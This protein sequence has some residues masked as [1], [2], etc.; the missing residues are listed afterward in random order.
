MPLENEHFEDDLLML[1]T[2]S[3]HVDELLYDGERV[4]KR[5]DLESATVV[6]TNERVLVFTEGG[7]G[8]NY[9]H[10]DR[11]NV[12]RVS[13]ENES[14]L[15]HLVWGTIVLFLAI[16]LFLLAATYD[17]ADA[18]DGVDPGDSTGLAGSVIDVVETLL[19][20]FDLT[21]FAAGGVVAL[22]G[23]IFFVRY[24]RSRSRHLVLR[25]SGDDDIVLPVTDADIEADR[26]VDLH[27]AIGPGSDGV[28]DAPPEAAV[29]SRESAGDAD[30]H[31]S[32]DDVAS[33]E[34]P[35]TDDA[36]ETAGSEHLLLDDPEGETTMGSD[37][38][39]EPEDES[40]DDLE[41]SNEPGQFEEG[42]APDEQHD[43]SD[44]RAN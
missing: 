19:T 30:E 7:N 38:Q 29:D 11:P 31:A 3:E 16:G 33:D 12:G 34:D 27:E 44:D 4:R 26:P 39:T 35:S 32:A 40:L 36:D 15:G 18:V 17:L 22:I 21:V 41:E 1:G 9:T 6:V 28:D 25:V 37:P 5:V 2:W 23:A 14:E 10:V 8:S 13:V 43:S 20:V 24:I 42:N